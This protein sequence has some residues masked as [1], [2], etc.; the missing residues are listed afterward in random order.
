M[1]RFS[2]KT[3][4]KAAGHCIPFLFLATVAVGLL[5]GG[6]WTFLTVVTVPL[7]LCALDL[8]LGSELDP[9]APQ[10]SLGYRSLPW[11]CVLGQVGL[12]IWGAAAVANPRTT[13]LEVLGETASVGFSAGIFGFLAAHEL[14]HRRSRS[15]RGLGLAMLAMVGYMHFR[16]AHIH[17]H[18]VRAA[19]LEDSATAR[20][21]EDAYSFIV[22]AVVGQVREAWVFESERLRRRRRP[23]FGVSNRML[24]YA[25]I[26]VLIGAGFASFGPRA[27]GFWLAQTALAIIM[28][29]LFNYIAHYGLL[30]RA[31]GGALERMGPRHSWNSA[32]RMNNWSL[33]NMG[34]HSDH[35]R[36]PSHAYQSLEPMDETPELPMG[37]AGSILLA[38]LP[39]LWRRVMD[40]RVDRWD[41]MPAET[42]PPEGLTG[43]AE[44][45]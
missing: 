15:E 3:A 38:L 42:T 13:L 37:Y 19:T 21:G 27:F 16:I 20:R 8:A 26:E 18:H 40:P 5:L 29:E 17:G 39:P 32:R 35:H 10:E 4:G 44:A 24:A 12:T 11:L 34:R 30:R 41:L 22:R 23:S 9:R 14:I 36:R 43:R 7:A 28:L 2:G 25:A 45:G 31:R 6:V 33:F 1:R